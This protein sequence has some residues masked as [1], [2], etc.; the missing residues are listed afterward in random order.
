MRGD[1]IISDDCVIK[2]WKLSDERM[3]FLERPPFSLAPKT[4]FV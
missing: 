3:K 1:T 4:S 2:Q